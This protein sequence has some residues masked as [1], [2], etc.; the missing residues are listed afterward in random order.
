MALCSGGEIVDESLRLVL[1]EQDGE[2]QGEVGLRGVGP[3]A[4]E[5][6]HQADR[7]C[8]AASPDA[9]YFF[10]DWPVL[11]NA[12]EEYEG[13]EKRLLNDSRPEEHPLPPHHLCCR[14]HF[15]LRV[16][17]TCEDWRCKAFPGGLLPQVW[18][19]V[20]EEEASEDGKK[21]ED[22]VQGGEGGHE[23]SGLVN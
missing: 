23:D 12:R 7:H 14:A 9:K 2:E 16:L 11:S 5:T 21:P 19:Q 6:L 20:V 22:Y 18:Q 3:D 13:I 15:E 1:E 17:V 10:K 8:K 4:A